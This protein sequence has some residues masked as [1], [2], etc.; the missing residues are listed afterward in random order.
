[1]S[2]FKGKADIRTCGRPGPLMT[3]TGH[4]RSDFAVMHDATFIC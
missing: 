2:A 3:H 4:R 1:M